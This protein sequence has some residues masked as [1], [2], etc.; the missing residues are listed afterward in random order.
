MSQV[1]TEVE[2]RPV[3][4]VMVEAESQQVNHMI[5]P[6]QVIHQYCDWMSAGVTTIDYLKFY[7]LLHF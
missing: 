7:Q 4:Q 3:S 2:S 1:I 6:T 5:K